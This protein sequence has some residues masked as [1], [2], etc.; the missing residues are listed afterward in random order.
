[1][2]SRHQNLCQ[3][4]T[5]AIGNT[6]LVSLSHRCTQSEGAILAKLEYLNPGHSKKDRAALQI[7]EDA[8]ARGELT[9]GQTVIE[10]TSGNM[11]TGLAIVCARRGYNFVAVMSRGN[12]PER[13]RMM[14]AL[15][16]EVILVDQAPGSREGEVSGEDLALV[17]QRT[18]KIAAARGAFRAD[19]FERDGNRLAHFHHTGTELIEQSNG[20]IDAFADFVGSGGTL[21]GVTQALKAYNPAIRCYAVEPF[22]AEAIAGGDQ[23]HPEHPIQGGGYNMDRLTALEGI[24]FDGHLT[25]TGEEAMRGARDLARLEGIFGGFSAGANLAAA[26]KLL[27]GPLRGATV[28]IV[29]CD[30]GL[31]Y[32]STDLWP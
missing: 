13:A 20:E 29:I 26:R 4:I 3:D 16:A 15:G 27:S 31:K 24:E 8:E 10:L 12:S 5:E 32:L 21:A 9:P 14:R 6:P 25:V 23:S 18:R 17:E 2:P 7:I 22:G 30:S 28:A 1:M 19:Q 11:G